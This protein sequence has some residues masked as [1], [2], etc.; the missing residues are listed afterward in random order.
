MILSWTMKIIQNCETLEILI[1][2]VNAGKLKPVVGHQQSAIRQLINNR[3]AETQV[4]RLGADETN[5][6][7]PNVRVSQNLVPSTSAGVSSYTSRARLRRKP[8]ESPRGRKKLLQRL[9]MSFV[10]FNDKRD[11]SQ[12]PGNRWVTGWVE[13]YTNL[14]N[15][16]A[17]VSAGASSYVPRWRLTQVSDVKAPINRPRWQQQAQ[18]GKTEKLL[19][20]EKQVG[21][22]VISPRPLV[23]RQA[24]LYPTGEHF[25][26]SNMRVDQKKMGFRGNLYL[27]LSM[28][29]K[30]GR[31]ISPFYSPNSNV[32]GRPNRALS[33]RA[34]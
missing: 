22:I 2:Y 14:D 6:S 8:G 1:S 25:I 17:L 29:R 33:L 4:C 16:R 30:V 21:R 26:W 32:A 20:A 18:W 12:E 34:L 31:T 11:S 3:H 24:M 19:S 7:Q 28:W 13:I 23:I 15:K 9:E 10:H 27:F 5:S